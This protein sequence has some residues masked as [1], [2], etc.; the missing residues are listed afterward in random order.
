MEYFVKI[1]RRSDGESVTFHYESEDEESAY[2]LWYDGNYSCDCNRELFFN[3][4]RGLDLDYENPCGR[5]RYDAEILMER[6]D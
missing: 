2:F 6:I 5:E 4:V 1:T 3:R